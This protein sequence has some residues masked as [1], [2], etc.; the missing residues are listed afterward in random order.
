[1]K[2]DFELLECCKLEVRN[3][4]S[5]NIYVDIP[6]PSQ[7]HPQPLV[8]VKINWKCGPCSFTPE[9]PTHKCK[10]GQSVDTNRKSQPYDARHAIIALSVG[11]AESP[12]RYF[13]CTDSTTPDQGDCFTM[14][15]NA[16]EAATFSTSCGTRRTMGDAKCRL[17]I[18]GC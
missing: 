12:W 18:A 17:T 11:R 2:S 3:G 9:P 7:Y 4:P 5:R 16:Q 15:Q 8:E 10:S 13:E 1:M 14:S 6:I